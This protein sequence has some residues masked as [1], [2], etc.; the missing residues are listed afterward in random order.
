MADIELT[1]PLSGGVITVDEDAAQ[2]FEQAG[3]RRAM[4]KATTRRGKSDDTTAAAG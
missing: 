4:K 3:F 1:D 2:V